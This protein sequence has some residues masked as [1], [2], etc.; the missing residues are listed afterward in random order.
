MSRT[1]L[2]IEFKI[3]DL[4]A[5]YEVVGTSDNYSFQ[6]DLGR[7]SE[8][9]DE[10][11]DTVFKE[12]PLQGNYGVFDVR[13][14][15]VSDI[16]IRSEFIQDRIEIFP[17]FLET[18]FTFSDINID[19]LPAD[20]SVGKEIILQPS[21][22]G[23]PLHIRS[24]YVGR[25]TEISWSLI[26]PFGH[27]NEGE[28]M[29]NE[30]LADS[31]FSKFSLSF[32]TGENGEAIDDA[33]LASSEYLKYH[34]LS[35][36]VPG[37]LDNYRE[38]SLNLEE[39]FFDELNIDRTLAVEI[40]AHDK[41]DRT[42]TGILTG[43]NYPSVIGN[44]TYNMRGAEFNASYFCN[45]TDFMNLNC[46]GFYI[47]QGIELYSDKSVSE[48]LDYY[49]SLQNAP[50]YS[51]LESV[52]YGIGDRVLYTDGKVYEAKNNHQNN[53]F[54][55]APPSTDF[56][57]D[58]GEPPFFESIGK[59][60][61]KD[62]FVHQQ[63]FGFD[64]YY[65]FAP[66]DEY[67]IQD[68]VNLTENG[69]EKDGV[70]KKITSSIKLDNIRFNE[71][72]DDLIFNWDVV[73]GAGNLVDLNQYKFMFKNGVV[74]GVVGISGSLFDPHTNEFL[75]GITE[76]ND[77]LS[78]DID[79]LGN[80]PLV[81]NIHNAKVFYNFE[82]TRELNNQIHGDKYLPESGKRSVGLEIGIIN[83]L[84]EIINKE[85]IIADNPPP[86]ILTKGF[87]SDSQDQVTKVK[88]NF[89]YANGRGEKTSEVLLYRSTDKDFSIVDSEGKLIREGEPFVKSVLGAG[90][91]TFGNNIN[92]I[93]DDAPP[94]GEEIT[95]YYYKILPFDDFG[96]G[97]V[98]GCNDNRGELDLVWV[99][100]SNYY[101]SSP[102]AYPGSALNI[103]TDEI[104]GPVVGFE[105][106]TA[107]ENYFLNWSKPNYQ[108]DDEGVINLAPLDIDHY[109]IWQSK[110]DKLEIKEEEN[111]L[112]SYENST[113]YRRV[114]GV[115][116]TVG[117]TPKEFYDFAEDIINAE[118]I[119]NID[120][121]A[122]KI[123]TSHKGS[124]NDKRYFWVR[125]V[126]YAGNKG[127]FTG[128]QNSTSQYVE[129]LELTLGQAKT[130]DIANFEQDI[131]N[132]FPNVLALVPN[133]PFS[134]NGNGISWVQHFLYYNGEG[135]V[136]TEG[137]TENPFVYFSATGEGVV[138]LVDYAE[139]NNID[140]GD[141]YKDLG[142]TGAG[143]GAFD[144][145]INNPL[146]NIVYSGSYNTSSYHPAG[147]GTQEGVDQKKPSLLGETDDFI[148]AKNAGGIPVPMWHAFA[149]ATIGT[150]HIQDA[151]ITNAKIHNLT[152]DKIR[153][154]VIQGQDIQ[155]AKAG[156][157]GQIRSA[158]F[159]GLNT[160][161]E[162]RNQPGFALS[163][164]GSFVF[165]T[166]NGKL[167]FDDEVLT[168]YGR[169]K[170]F[171]G[172][173][174]TFLDISAEPKSF[175]YLE[176]SDGSYEPARNTDSCIF[177]ATYQNSEMTQDDIR[178]RISSPDGLVDFVSYEEFA[179]SKNK[180]A[181][182]PEAYDI[183][184]F[185]Y[186][187]PT[188]F[189][190]YAGT[191]RAK[192][193]RA[194][195][196]VTGFN[197]MIS[198]D[199]ENPNR[200]LPKYGSVVVH[201]SG[202]GTSMERSLAVDFV[203][204]GKSTTY[205]D[206]S[207]N[208]QI[209]NYDY[210][211]NYD[212]SANTFNNN[213]LSLTT[214]LIDELESEAK[215]IFFTGQNLNPENLIRLNYKEYNDLDPSFFISDGY[216]VK[217]GNNIYEVIQDHKKDPNKLPTNTSYWRVN[218]NQDSIKKWNVNEDD[219]TAVLSKF[220]E[221]L[222][223]FNKTPFICKAS[224]VHEN[225]DIDPDS[226]TDDPRDLLLATDFVT[227]YGSKPGNDAYTV[228]LDNENH[229]YVA[230]EF[231][232]VDKGIF[233]EGKTAVI[234][235]RGHEYYD[236][237]KYDVNPQPSSGYSV[238]AITSS[239]KVL[240]ELENEDNYQLSDLHKGKFVINKRYGENV[241]R[242]VTDSSGN[243]QT[244]KVLEVEFLN[245]PDLDNDTVALK[246]P[247]F[248]NK[249]RGN[250]YDSDFPPVEF[251]K[252]YTFSKAKAGSSGR[253]IEIVSDSQ[254][255]EYDQ[256]GNIKSNTSDIT[257]G[258]EHFNFFGTGQNI[259]LEY[260]RYIKDSQTGESYWEEILNTSGD[261][262]DKK[263]TFSKDSSNSLLKIPETYGDNNLPIRIRCV[264]YDGPTIPD[265]DEDTP[266]AEDRYTIFGLKD[267]SD[268][269]TVVMSQEFSNVPVTLGADNQEN[270][271]FDNTLN[272]ISV[273]QGTS[274]FT[275]Q[276]NESNLSFKEFHIKAT[277]SGVA[278][279][280]STT[281]PSFKVASWTSS[282]NI[283]HI[284]YEITV[285]DQN[286]KSST[287][288]RRQGLSKGKNGASARAVDL[289][290]SEQAVSYGEDNLT[291]ITPDNITITA[292]PRNNFGE[293]EF[294]KYSNSSGL[295]TL[296]LKDGSSYSGNYIEDNEIVYA[297][298]NKISV[299]S[300]SLLATITCSFS[301]TGSANSELASDQ[302][303][304]FALRAG[305]NATTI[306][307]SNE[308]HGL[309]YD[310]ENDP[311]PTGSGTNIQVFIGSA[312]L[313]PKKVN[314]GSQLSDGEFF[315]QANPSSSNITA[316]SQ[317]IS[318]KTLIFADASG[319]KSTDNG[320]FIDYNITVK[321]FKGQV[322][323]SPFVRKQT[324]SVTFKGDKGDPGDKGDRGSGPSYR[325]EWNS[326]TNYKG[327]VGDNLNVD[328]VRYSGSDYIAL[329]DNVNK[330]PDQNTSDW[331]S[332]GA[333][334]SSVATKLLITESSIV[335]NEIKLGED[336]SDEN[337][338]IQ[339]VDGDTGPFLIAG[340]KGGINTFKLGISE[341]DIINI[342]RANISNGTIAGANITNGTISNVSSISSTGSIANNNITLSASGVI[343]C[344]DLYASGDVIAQYTQSDILLKDNIFK[345]ENPLS[346]ILSLRG[347]EF[348]WNSKSKNHV[349]KDYGLIAQEVRE[350]A[351]FLVRERSDGYL[352]LKYEGIIPFLVGAI[353]EQ[354]EKINSL[355]KD[356]K[357]I[358]EK[359]NRL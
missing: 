200:V 317:S 341:N 70:L 357:Q 238:G 75:S 164:D 107:F 205:M 43:I 13:V 168:L 81:E 126:D 166:E 234:F 265:P 12:V 146:R 53:P 163:G 98:F 155:L 170:Q 38:F 19:N 134:S 175:M 195:F 322:S 252:I 251:E 153:S 62:S 128:V 308:H 46:Q 68:Y 336:T 203:A 194:T 199:T 27:P 329:R 237:K 31:F 1:A 161:H 167:F 332:L 157:K 197:A 29:S 178:F 136:V 131:T 266:V 192:T 210:D 257:V 263:I 351:P 343:T 349:G 114:R 21:S 302:I 64:Y 148:I 232:K 94:V 116:Y 149:N 41:F 129:G 120:A 307:L 315:V 165:Q 335:K 225:Q 214:D 272:E 88:F 356:I 158:G 100:P 245:I 301:E 289:I 258:V 224:A 106:D 243:Q 270:L 279:D 20:A 355:E 137:D 47:Q 127:P 132:A 121:N 285:K 74:P 247:V 218:P 219:G 122:P 188:D 345:I 42:T 288:N 90:D 176:L 59:V 323:S 297:P 328:I 215:I 242:I 123:Q 65:S 294:Y 183:S 67:G 2:G 283:A 96:S 85:R 133:N 32:R 184:G 331:R 56:W 191:T 267:G 73:D 8:L 118:N 282:S 324:F 60:G 259:L 228:L 102:N 177:T 5:E 11:G 209:Y 185:R 220:D 173:E 52:F 45:D 189:T 340:I 193:A 48:N 69:L 91:L 295:G 321:D 82:Y 216:N 284:D 348:E 15:A 171:D 84:G 51:E 217:Y 130:T 92:Q 233:D 99:L 278:L 57:I 104:P 174:F 119:F 49:T 186:N 6:Y 169:I 50:R 76:G 14:F 346:K 125:P 261:K 229:T 141:L 318:S 139:E 358:K 113:G 144:N 187:P 172:A 269:I 79:D 34:L 54:S 150:A 316:G 254:T 310:L 112:G 326:A 222:D 276:G 109:E 264:A 115:Q 275:Y 138:K 304:I 249:Y 319:F 156:G 110:D 162:I 93:I 201:V 253:G 305:S 202:E 154:E 3:N 352:G 292:T 290:A 240:I 347:I 55:T 58:L 208:N 327:A 236:Y 22:Q 223:T 268:A 117:E 24:E 244:V 306:I 273:F 303:S 287:F 143:G 274:A 325:G 39:P 213:T 135:Y 330:R 300:G 339:T 160:N 206:L 239:S 28:V 227:I 204:D 37:A 86:V 291:K 286:G 17:N 33:T 230:D 198:Y 353:K 314:S 89:N 66:V 344:T 296:K 180:N 23:D 342:N 226:E 124:V 95:G 142:L 152:A 248:D 281:K 36:D 359:I 338:Y 298:P 101:S 44:F 313:T 111:Y 196:D 9:V 7:G 280:S 354:Q 87:A 262:G 337:A 159:E 18:T 250:D 145:S 350:V 4:D 299:A 25:R 256:L 72:E 246:I 182:L 16:G 80:R 108:I 147:E 241:T 181:A 40:V 71:R 105:G 26:A 61:S 207:V 231:G 103:T 312:I 30:L 334:F 77:T 211:G 140:V 255:I 212:P 309:T 333:Q 221:E 311:S 235:R 10:E 190:D 277:P 271:N 63:K 78:S 35:D 293:V 260:F 151:A 83:N 179:N 97:E 320:E